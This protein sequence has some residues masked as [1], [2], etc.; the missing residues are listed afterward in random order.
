MN[1]Y[2]DWVKKIHALTDP[3][4]IDIR[5]EVKYELPEPSVFSGGWCRP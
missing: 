2:V 1:S 3:H 4:D 5:T